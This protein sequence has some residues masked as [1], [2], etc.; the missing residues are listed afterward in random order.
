[1][2]SRGSTFNATQSSTWEPLLTLGSSPYWRLGTGNSLQWP[3]YGEYGLENLAFGPDGPTIPNATVAMINATEYWVGSF[4]LGASAGNFSYITPNV[5][6]AQ[7]ETLG[8]I[9]SAGYGY[10]AGAI[11]RKYFIVLESL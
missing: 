1:M 4:G 8:D 6:F 10:T 7:L 5:T 2:N 9:V 3:P 11:Y